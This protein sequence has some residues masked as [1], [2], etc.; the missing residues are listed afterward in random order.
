[1][2]VFATVQDVVARTLGVLAG[3]VTLAA[4]KEQI[5]QWDSFRHLE[6]VMEIEAAFGMSFTMEEMTLMNSVPEI[7]EVVSRKLAE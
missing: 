4:S 3:D 5:P 7:V 6:V 1:M 2:D